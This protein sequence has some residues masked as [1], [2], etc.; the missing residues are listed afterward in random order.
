MVISDETRP[1][2]PRA[3]Q[4]AARGTAVI[5]SESEAAARWGEDGLPWR[6]CSPTDLMDCLR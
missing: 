4:S 5:H 1:A 2:T 6:R 3:T